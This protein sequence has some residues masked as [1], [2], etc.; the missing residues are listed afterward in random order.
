MTEGLSVG[1]KALTD[2]RWPIDNAT[3]LRTLPAKEFVSKM[4]SAIHSP[5][6]MQVSVDG[7]VLTDLPRNMFFT[8]SGLSA[9]E[10]VVGFT[11]LDGIISELFGRI[12]V[13][14]PCI[15]VS[16]LRHST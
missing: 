4:L 2:N 15:L 6:G 8:Y 14:S 11:S 16:K 9:E 12:S 13:R 5:V 7:L 3:F 1:N 10:I